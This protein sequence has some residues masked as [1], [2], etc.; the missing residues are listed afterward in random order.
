MT[1][2]PTKSGLA[3]AV[4]AMNDQKPPA[5]LMKAAT[6]GHAEPLLHAEAIRD[7]LLREIGY[8]MLVDLIDLLQVPKT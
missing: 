7:S 1:V 5:E 4:R 3:A 2:K 8:D 6:V